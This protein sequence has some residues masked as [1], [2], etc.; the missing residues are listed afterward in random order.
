MI[1]RICAAYIIHCDRQHLHKQLA[2]AQGGKGDEPWQQ[3]DGNPLTVLC[4]PT[5]LN[6]GP[7]LII[8][9]HLKN[10]DHSPLQVHR[11]QN[12][13]NKLVGSLLDQNL[14]I[15]KILVPWISV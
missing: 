6:I 14:I 1:F 7:S 5:G 4:Q 13:I 3:C 9:F 2:D 10:C 8:I 15:E 11:S 12:L